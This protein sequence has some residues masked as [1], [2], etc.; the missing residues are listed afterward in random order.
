MTNALRFETT[1]TMPANIAG[2]VQ[3]VTE[4][5][6]VR[7]P[8]MERDVYQFARLT[9]RA[10]FQ[11]TLASAVIVVAAIHL[12]FVLNREQLILLGVIGLALAAI[13]S[14]AAYVITLHTQ[15]EWYKEQIVR[16]RRYGLIADEE[17]GRAEFQRLAANPGI[18][19]ASRYKSWTENK[20]RDFGRVFVSPD[21]VWIGEEQFVRRHING[22]IPNP[23]ENF[24]LIRDDF[25]DW[26][27]ITPEQL[28]T[29][30]GRTRIIGWA[31]NPPTPASSLR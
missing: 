20:K 23:N 11:F 8:R 10:M 25:I 1:T 24:P 19:R 6:T 21:G 16:R 31:M 27:W 18:R 12:V 30:Y 5:D 2:R 28:W 22:L 26:G 13:I 4:E 7:S 17:P 15:L 29:A 14:A 3:H 9:G